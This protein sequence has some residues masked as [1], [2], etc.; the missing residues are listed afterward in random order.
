MNTPMTRDKSPVIVYDIQELM[1]QLAKFVATQKGKNL[2][3]TIP[4]AH[5]LLGKWH[6]LQRAHK[7]RVEQLFLALATNLTKLLA[8]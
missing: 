2:Q 3:K 5:A 8:A 4:I 1:K 7:N 6:K